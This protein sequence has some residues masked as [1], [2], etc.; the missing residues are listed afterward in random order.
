MGDLAGMVHGPD[1]LHGTIRFESGAEPGGKLGSICKGFGD[2][3]LAEAQRRKDVLVQSY[4]KRDLQGGF[5]DLAQQQESEVRIS[6]ALAGG[7]QEPSL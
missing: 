6:S 7:E 2:E 3:R 1:V 5:D 4:S